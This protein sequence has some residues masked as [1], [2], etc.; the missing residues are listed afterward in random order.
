MDRIF[1]SGMAAI[2][3]LI[4]GLMVDICYF[5]Y[6][7]I[8][9]QQKACVYQLSAGQTMT[10]V[11]DTLYQR[12][13]LTQKRHVYYLRQL[14]I[15]DGQARHIKAGEY[16]IDQ[17]LTPRQLLQH[18]VA[19]DVVQHD[20]IFVEGWT[21]A[22]MLHALRQH[23]ALQHDLADMSVQQMMQKLAIKYTH[24]EGLFFSRYLSFYSWHGRTQRIKGGL[25]SNAN[26][27]TTSLAA[28]CSRFAL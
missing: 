3:L 2:V 21:F 13:I 28:T 17:Q 12:G 8:L 23:E 20:I 27:S 19:G 14:A 11:A 26:A 6:Q 10:Q 1:Y 7:P 18:L 16:T 4:L 5:V 24:P 22:Q 15:W 25:S 9:H